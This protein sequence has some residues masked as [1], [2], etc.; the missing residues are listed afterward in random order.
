MQNVY[1]FCGSAI[2]AMRCFR[3]QLPIQIT[4]VLLNFA[5]CFLLIGRHGFLGAAWAM[6]GA[7][8]FEAVAYTSVF[9]Y[10][11]MAARKPIDEETYFVKENL[12]SL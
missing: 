3:V 1:V 8:V 10:L 6:F 2:S 7:N 11:R 9:L 5:L 12:A 4:S